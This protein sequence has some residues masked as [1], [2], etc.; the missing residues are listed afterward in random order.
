M[1]L[2][3]FADILLYTFFLFLQNINYLHFKLKY[4]LLHRLSFKYL[5]FRLTFANNRNEILCLTV[6]LF[7]KHRCHRSE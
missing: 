2:F 4:L 3:Y 7:F 1:H 5:Q 6:F